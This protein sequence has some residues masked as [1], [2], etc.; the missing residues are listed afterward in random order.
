VRALEVHAWS[1]LSPPLAEGASSAG[2]FTP[3]LLG[4]YGQASVTHTPFFSHHPL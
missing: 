3:A 4:A 1:A 2:A